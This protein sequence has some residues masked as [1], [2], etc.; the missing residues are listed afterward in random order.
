[1]PYTGLKMKKYKLSNY[2]ALSVKECKADIV[3]ELK[4][5]EN[6]HVILSKI[7]NIIWFI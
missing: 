1:M 5:D 6:F 2:T 4:K 3:G 7:L